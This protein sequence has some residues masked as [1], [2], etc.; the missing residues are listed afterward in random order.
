[1]SELGLGV[2]NQLTNL[3]ILADAMWQESVWS[4]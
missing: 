4:I 2:N 3:L 1:M